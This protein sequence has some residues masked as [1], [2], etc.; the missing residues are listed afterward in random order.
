MAEYMINESVV[1]A[2]KY[3]CNNQSTIKNF[4]KGLDYEIIT[5]N[6]MGGLSKVVIHMQTHNIEV[7]EGEYLVKESD[8]NMYTTKS[9][10]NVE[11]L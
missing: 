1:N 4:L 8:G 9:L 6:H 2:V 3:D 11:L 10:D 7:N 5:E